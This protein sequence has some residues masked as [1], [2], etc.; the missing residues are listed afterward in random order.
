MVLVRKFSAHSLVGIAGSG[1]AAAAG[2]RRLTGGYRFWLGHQAIRNITERTCRI[3]APYHEGNK[4]ANVEGCARSGDFVG[5]S[6]ADNPKFIE[7]TRK[8]SPVIPRR[9]TRPR[10]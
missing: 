5:Q 2:E 8:K 6:K 7:V 9:R 1:M 4:A 10:K 3:S